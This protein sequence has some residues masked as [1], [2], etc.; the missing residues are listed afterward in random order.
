MSTILVTT[1]FSALSENAAVYAAGLARE[2][3]C[4]LVLLH[5]FILPV[6]VTPS[7]INVVSGNDLYT[8]AMESM[9]KL[10]TK[11]QDTGFRGE[12]KK[13]VKEGVLLEQMTETIQ[14]EEPF[15]IVMATTG[16]GKFE[17]LM[18]G[19]NTFSAIQEMHVPV[20]VVPGN[21]TYKPIKK[22]GVSCDFKQ[23]KETVPNG[24]VKSFASFLGA[25]LHFVNVD[26][27]NEQFT[28]NTPGEFRD[29]RSEF[30]NEA[31]HFIESKDIT[32]GIESFI[33][34]VQI[35]C[36]MMFPRKHGLLNQ[37]FGESN[38]RKIALHTHIPVLAIHK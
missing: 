17:T 37:I 3:D 5:S 6:S 24:L 19:S 11:L 15:L 34:D 28:T 32:E 13:I 20:M 27:N 8:A 14:A 16:K 25:E 26:H 4:R 36:L 33:N 22:L 7:S 30:P 1:D 38:T 10:E 21:A 2:K 31:I 18:I 23:V 35:D 9:D 12:I 29:I